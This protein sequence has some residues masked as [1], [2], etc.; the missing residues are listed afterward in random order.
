[1]ATLEYNSLLE[2]YIDFTHPLSLIRVN[3]KDISEN[4]K[5][6]V[7]N[8]IEVDL[9]SGYEASVASFCIYN[10]FNLIESKF[11]TED[12]KKYLLIGS[13]L[14]ISLGYNGVVKKVFLGVITKVNFLFSQDEIPHIQV[15]AMDLK[16]LMMSNHYAKQI[17]KTSYSEAVKEILSK[18]AYQIP[19]DPNQPS[20]T[21]GL[22]GNLQITDTPDKK[23]NSGES[24]RESAYT[25][26][27]VNESD[28]EFVVK[29]AKKFNYEFF[30][31]CDTVY[32]RKAKSVKD[33]LFELSS[34]NILRDF[35]IE[36]DVTGLVQQIEARAMD[37]G[38][39]RAIF[40]SKRYTNKISMGGKAKRLLEGSQKIYID[41]TINSREDADYRVQS[42]MEDMSYRFGSLTCTT[43]GIPDLSPGYFMD[44]LNLGAPVDNTFYIVNV[45]HV[46]DK[47]EG[48]K[49]Y[50]KGKA[51]SLR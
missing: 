39:A 9:T 23:M 36:Y 34:S 18:T 43:V 47:D 48:Y 45:R 20:E 8:D 4:K 26:E 22:I 44:V 32:F 49:T 37:A 6:L 12:I 31:D 50:L 2:S 19:K 3:G 38:K 7:I 25:I 16:G 51:A 40:A 27:M 15:T 11:I 30:T 13:R 1:M 10:C 28:Y 42:L 14:E 21:S 35:D 29:A 24:T 17:K 41:P 46:F 5:G 33:I